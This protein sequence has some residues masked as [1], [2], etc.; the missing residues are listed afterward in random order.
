M[1]IECIREHQVKHNVTEIPEQGYN[2]EQNITKGEEFIVGH[3]L[4]ISLHFNLKIAKHEF[5]INGCI[6]TSY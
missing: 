4:T 3:G 6:G 2:V 1:F 5:I